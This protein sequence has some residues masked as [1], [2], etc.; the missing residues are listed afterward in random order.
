MT[1]ENDKKTFLMKVDKSKKGEIDDR[2]IS[3]MKTINAL[4]DF[5]TTSS[6]SGR[7]Y[8]WQGTGK[9]NETEWIK[10]SHDLIDDDFFRLSGDTN[11]GVVWLRMEGF[12]MHIACRDVVKANQ[13]LE[14]VRRVYKKSGFL[15]VSNKII[16]E[17][18]G[19]E[20][21]E[22]PWLLDGGKLFS[23][24]VQWLVGLLNSKLK[25]VWGDMKQLEK[26]IQLEEI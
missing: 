22:M 19:S 12:I 16:L 11:K 1:F 17:I 13:L 14:K 2:V 6:C 3:L 23:G 18:R 5:Y 15:G 10:V 9:K 8:L 25:K 21:M 7:V 20:F 26:V 24:E 4:P